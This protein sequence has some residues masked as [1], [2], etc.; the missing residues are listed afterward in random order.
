MSLYSLAYK[1]EAFRYNMF[2]LNRESIIQ[3]GMLLRKN[4]P[5][6]E[7]LYR[8]S[9]SAVSQRIKSAAAL[10]ARRLGSGEGCDKVFA[11][12]EMAVFP[13]ITRYILA[14]PLGDV[15]KGRLIAD[16]KYRDR[17]DF[18]LDTALTYPAISLGMA[19]LT[20][21][22]LYIFV[23]PQFREIFAGL[24]V[25]STPFVDWMLRRCDGFLLWDFAFVAGF[26]FLLQL[27]VYAT[28]HISGFSQKLDEMNLLRM[29]AV[30]PL[31]E[32]VRAIEVMAVKSYF[33]A[34][35]NRFRRFAQ[36]LASGSDIGTAGNAAGVSDMLTWFIGLAINDDSGE[37][38]L[39]DEAADYCNASVESSAA[40]TVSMLEVASTL[41]LAVVFGTTAYALVQMMILITESTFS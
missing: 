34:L 2:G 9:Q 18:R 16:W 24:G 12:A 13:A 19:G 37:T 6:A 20:S 7:A 4:V 28:R 25:K 3:L 10:A 26:V 29:L 32:R 8:V 5:L 39:L 35:H 22:S 30:L 23:F 1:I 11:A 33:P 31:E 38:T 40:K 21:M 15:T 36:A 17:R 27:V 14:S 41:F